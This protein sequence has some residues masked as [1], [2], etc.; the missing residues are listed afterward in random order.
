[1]GKKQITIDPKKWYSLL[2]IHE[3]E[4]LKGV[5]PSDDYRML[6]VYVERKM[7]KATIF[8][9]GRAKRYHVKGENLIEFAAK[10]EAGDFGASK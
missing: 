8:G 2:E 6:R 10:W 4:Y 7:L 5:V 9:E 3:T 1:M